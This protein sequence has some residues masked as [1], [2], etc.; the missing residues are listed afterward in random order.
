MTMFSRFFALTALLFATPLAAQQVPAPHFVFFD[1]GK[2]EL[3]GDAKAEIDKVAAEY[4]TKG[5]GQV[6]LAAYTDRSGDA[7]ANRTISRKRGE[8]VKAYLVGKGVAADA[9]RVQAYGEDHPFVA[10]DDGV[11]EVQ[12]RRVDIWVVN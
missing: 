10:T 8:L 6:V 3:S 1:W 11:R 9:I 5:G 4:A 7:R 2:N 12:N